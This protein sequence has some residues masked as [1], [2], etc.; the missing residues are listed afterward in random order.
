MVT[1]LR[2]KISKVQLMPPRHH[3]RFARFQMV[4]P[5]KQAKAIGITAKQRVAIAFAANPNKLGNVHQVVGSVAAI[6]P[7]SRPKQAAPGFQLLLKNLEK[8]RLNR[9]AGL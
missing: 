2:N 3:R 1:E 5:S 4:E 7:D 6:A 9:I 8:A